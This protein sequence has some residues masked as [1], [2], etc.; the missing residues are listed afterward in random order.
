MH[1]FYSNKISHVLIYT[2]FWG[3][4]WNNLNVTLPPW[5]KLV[6]SSWVNF[7]LNLLASVLLL[8]LFL[9]CKLHLMSP[10]KVHQPGLALCSS[11]QIPIKGA[12][13]SFLSC[14]IWVHTKYFNVCTCWS[15]SFLVWC[16]V[17]ARWLVN[18][19][20]LITCLFVNLFVYHSLPCI[21]CVIIRNDQSEHMR[22]LVL[23]VSASHTEVFLPV[24]VS[25][26]DLAA[27]TVNWAQYA[28]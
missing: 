2:V 10:E 5:F 24:V 9:S 22:W 8:F 6:F 7:Y 16:T 18:I 27:L 4:I 17:D 13:I 12:Q 21:S 23:V 3:S 11:I 28:A 14:K 26:A 19:T 20:W 15:L 1:T 25:R